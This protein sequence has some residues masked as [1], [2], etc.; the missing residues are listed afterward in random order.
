VTQP[1][2]SVTPAIQIHSSI[3]SP[4]IHRFRMLFLN[5]AA[6]AACVLAIVIEVMRRK[7]T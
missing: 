4:P 6:L 7:S 1:N 3:G 5:L 2:S